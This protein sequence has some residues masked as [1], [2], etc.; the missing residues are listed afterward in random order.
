MVAMLEEFE[1]EARNRLRYHS[2]YLI[3]ML[4]K[5]FEAINNLIATRYYKNPTNKVREMVMPE[6]VSSEVFHDLYGS[7]LVFKRY[8]LERI[9]NFT[10]H[11]TKYLKM[12]YRNLKTSD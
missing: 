8:K 11:T 5:L 4:G 3:E 12:R 10:P 1:E 9:R 6:G 2:S 7:V